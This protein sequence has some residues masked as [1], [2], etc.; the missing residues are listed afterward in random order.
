MFVKYTKGTYGSARS[1]SATTY[2]Y[3]Y[4]L[5]DAVATTLLH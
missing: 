4:I 1:P 5:L 2:H 3:Y